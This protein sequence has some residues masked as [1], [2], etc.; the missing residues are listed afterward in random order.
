M[1]HNN[2]KKIFSRNFIIILLLI[3]QIS[4]ILTCFLKLYKYL[5][6]IYGAQTILSIILICYV[7]N[8]QA[9][10]P[11]YKLCWSMIIML[12]PILGAFMYFFAHSDLGM[13]FFKESKNKMIKMTRPLLP[14]NKDI[15]D[16]L[17]DANLHMAH[18]SEYINKYAGYPT[19]ID[20]Y[21]EYYALGEEK[22]ASLIRELEKAEHYIFMEY[23]ILNE[24]K[25]WDTILKILERKAEQGVEVRVM[26]DGMG[27]QFKLPNYYNRYIETKGIKCRVFNEFRPFLSTM[28]NNR[29]HRKILVIDGITAFNG[30]VNLADEYINEIERFGHWKDTAVMIKG[31]AVW[32]YTVMFIQ[33]WDW[34]SKELS[35]YEKYKPLKCNQLKLQECGYVIPYADTPTDNEL[36]GEYV[37][38]NIINKAKKYVY[39]T[40]P[41]LIID[42]EMITALGYA[43]KSGVDIKIIV[44]HIPDKWYVNLVGWNY[45][46]ELINLG[47]EIYEYMPGFIHA[48]NFISDDSVATVG[49][50]NLDYRSLYLHFECGTLLY[51]CSAV[52]DIKLDFMNTLAKSRKI[53][54]EDCNNRPLI[55]RI[56]G[57]ILRLIAPLL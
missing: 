1:K 49:T 19:Y 30:G 20:S 14:Q 8:K 26:Y 16:R 41:Y 24:G 25:M 34:K 7:V 43:V 39:I 37:Y 10:N 13:V 5:T 21:V 31:D 46:K 9:T 29:D 33:M 55:K 45:Y 42:N 48:K 11:A 12:I 18:L 17:E 52:K 53:T 6:V 36:V 4:F 54:V 47:I 57:G 23:F 40:T 3:V 2:F 50:I 56:T 22:Y 15:T 38:L 27:S 32:S 51:E 35:N 28:H 44:P